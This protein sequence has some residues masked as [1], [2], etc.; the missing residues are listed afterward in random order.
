VAV[1][2]R[3]FR[4]HVLRKQ[5]AKLPIYIQEVAKAVESATGGTLDYLIIVAALATNMNKP[6]LAL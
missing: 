1:E 3:L 5:S 2:V 4:Q 6:I